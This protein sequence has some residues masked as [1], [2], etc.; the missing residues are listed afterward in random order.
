MFDDDYL[1]SF[2]RLCGFRLLVRANRLGCAAISR[3]SLMT[4]SSP[5][6]AR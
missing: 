1:A 4:G 6:S 2:T 5:S 3:A